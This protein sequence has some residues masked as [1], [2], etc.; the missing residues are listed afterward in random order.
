VL[1][2]PG[3]RE[4]LFVGLLFGVV[5]FLWSAGSLG[6]EL[7]LGDRLRAGTPP[8]ASFGLLD[9]LWHLATGFIAALPARQ[10]TLLWAAPAMSLGL[11]I[12]HLF[13]SYLPTVLI[14]P[15]HN[16]FLIAILAVV[17]Y[18]GAGRF[19]MSAAVAAV[20][21]HIGVDGGTFPLFAPASLTMY[22]LAYPVQLALIVAAVLLYFLSVRPLGRLKDRR[23]VLSVVV[24]VG[25]LAVLLALIPA[26]FAGFTSN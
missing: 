15:A 23:A 14:R 11:D 16:L 21:V 4:G 7:L 12:D 18:V 8:G 5:V 10:R 26:G 17:L 19:G 20:L 3:T 2:A 9:G 1:L 24:S 6:I 25:V 22:P 13:G